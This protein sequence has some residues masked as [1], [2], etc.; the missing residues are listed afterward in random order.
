MGRLAAGSRRAVDENTKR[1]RKRT[2]ALGQ[3]ILGDGCRDERVGS[4]ASFRQNSLA[5]FADLGVIGDYGAGVGSGQPLRWFED[6]SSVASAF[7]S[8][9]APAFSRFTPLFQ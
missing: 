6:V 8:G 7:R 5:N 2:G 9:C 1:A 3:N 4:V